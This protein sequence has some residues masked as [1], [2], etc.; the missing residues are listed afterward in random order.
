MRTSIDTVASSIITVDLIRAALRSDDLP[1]NMTELWL[2]IA[3][4]R[5]EKF[6]LLIAKYPDRE[7]APSRDIDLMWH[8]H[9]QHPRQYV[10][11]CYRLF[12]DILDHDG[13][14]GADEAEIPILDRIFQETARLWQQE[15]S[16]PY[17]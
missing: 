12:G 6:L 2:R 4:D 7:L 1:K 15:Y 16:E 9:M 5:Y 17:T 10:A 14:F 11:D 3:L 8:L 13:G